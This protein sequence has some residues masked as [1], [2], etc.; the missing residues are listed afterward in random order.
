MKNL[1]FIIKINFEKECDNIEHY[2]QI[3][4]NMN[5]LIECWGLNDT[6]FKER[7]DF[8]IS[9]ENML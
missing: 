5:L 8:I 1:L 7:V 6:S 3:Q 4:N 9:L 2:G